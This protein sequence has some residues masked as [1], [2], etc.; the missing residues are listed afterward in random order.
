MQELFSMKLNALGIRDTK[1][2]AFILGSDSDAE[3]AAQEIFG[4]D[5]SPEVQSTLLSL[6][7]AARGPGK[8]VIFWESKQ[9]RSPVT[10]SAT[11][12]AALTSILPL[13]VKE[14]VGSLLL[15]T[16]IAV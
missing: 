14:E 6:W 15:K 16:T 1:D 4:V 8:A 12:P 11:A 13:K 10:K 5:N 9:I 7:H 3:K 2:L